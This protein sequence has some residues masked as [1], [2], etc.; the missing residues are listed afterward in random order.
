MKRIQYACLTE[1]SKFENEADFNLYIEKLNKKGA[2]FEIVE[3]I[4]EPD[5]S[6]TVET[7]SQYLNYKTGKYL[8]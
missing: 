3:K 5:G 4:T 8:Q 7:K 6:V 2:K 1:I